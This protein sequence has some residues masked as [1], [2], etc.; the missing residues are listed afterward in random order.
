MTN[1]LGSAG[2][3]S[4]NFQI[5]AYYQVSVA[6]TANSIGS[7]S[8]TTDGDSTFRLCI[9]QGTCS[10][11]AAADI[12]PNNFGV[13]IAL[14]NGRVLTSPST[15]FVPQR[16]ICPTQQFFVPL[17]WQIDFPPKS[18]LEFTF[19]D[20][21]GDVNTVTFVLVGYKLFGNGGGM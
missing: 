14:Q 10:K 20:L 2:Q 3:Q 19:Q 6:L 1:L 9:F 21:S 4:A 17:S 5:P 16:V 7:T 18:I 13:R 12:S 15:I 11:D 8:L